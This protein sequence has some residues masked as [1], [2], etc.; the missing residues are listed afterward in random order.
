MITLLA[1][2]ALASMA[3]TASADPQVGTTTTA[4]QITPSVSQVTVTPSPTASPTASPSPAVQFRLF[5]DLECGANN[6]SAEVYFGEIAIGDL[7]NTITLGPNIL[8]DRVLSSQAFQT[9]PDANKI[10]FGGIWTGG[11]ECDSPEDSS[12]TYYISEGCS[13]M[14]FYDD[15]GTIPGADDSDGIY[16]GNLTYAKLGIFPFGSDL[17]V[18]PTVSIKCDAE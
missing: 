2:L 16:P 12:Y 6:P 17:D 4:I 15:T 8:R 13:I 1:T 5:T 3:F 18:P 9:V 7:D 14:G 11:F 10:A